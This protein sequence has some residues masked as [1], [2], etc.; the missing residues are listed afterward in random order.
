MAA[1]N[2]LCTGHILYFGNE[3]QKKRWLPKLAAADW[4]GAW[5]LTEHSTGSDAGSMTTSA[6]KEE[7]NWVINVTKNFIKHAISCDIAVVMDAIENVRRQ[8][9]GLNEG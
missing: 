8:L 1:H 9:S 2:S 4:I 6:I 3:E 5:G 7:G